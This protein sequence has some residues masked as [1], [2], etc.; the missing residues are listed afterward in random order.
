M[1]LIEIHYYEPKIHNLLG[2][3]LKQIFKENEFE[4]NKGYFKEI[5]TK[6]EES[7]KPSSLFPLLIA[8]KNLVC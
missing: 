1:P 8:L 3:T 6:L 2:A 5:G 4:E 7:L